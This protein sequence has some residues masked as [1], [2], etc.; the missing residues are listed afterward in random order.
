MFIEYSA[1]KTTNM[2][3]YEDAWTC[4][5]IICYDANSLYL[6]WAKQEMFIGGE[7]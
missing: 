6:P 2:P 1:Y 5:T 4:K 3:K 7:Y